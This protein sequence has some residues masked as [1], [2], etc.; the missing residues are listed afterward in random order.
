MKLQI[1]RELVVLDLETTGLSTAK[2]RIIQIAL[3][4]VFPDGRESE[5]KTRYVNP[6][7]LI[8]EEVTEITGITNEMVK[9]EPPFSKLAKGIM[10]YIGNADLL[11]FNGN[12]FDIPLLIQSFWRCGLTLEME[13]RRYIDAKRIFHRMDP[14]DLG[15]A[16]RKFVGRPMENAHDAGADVKATYDVLEAMLDFYDGAVLEEKTERI[17]NP[18]QNSVQSLYEFTKDFDELDYEGWI[19]LKNGVPCFGKGK[20]QGRPIGENLVSD[21]KYM[22]WIMNIGDFTND[23]RTK[24]NKVVTEYRKEMYEKSEKSKVKQ[25]Q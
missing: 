24:I 1:D 16:H 22:D 9:N 19:K 20:Y 3:M 23:T 10:A 11:T 13:N 25:I 8:P 18:V 17:E 15:A 7:M 6:E 14:R 4:K 21:I 12:R 5:L 2:D